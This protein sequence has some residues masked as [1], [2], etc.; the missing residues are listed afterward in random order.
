MKTM[1]CFTID[2]VLNKLIIKYLEICSVQVA[3]LPSQ[4][5]N[6]WSMDNAF[7]DIC[8]MNINIY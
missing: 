7:V 4:F 8:K 1:L 6:I 5:I 3:V 2:L